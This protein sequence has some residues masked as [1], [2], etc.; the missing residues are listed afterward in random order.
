MKNNTWSTGIIRWQIWYRW[1]HER[2]GR[3]EKP[4]RPGCTNF[5]SFFGTYSLGLLDL[6]GPYGLVLVCA[7][8]GPRMSVSHIWI[9]STFP[10]TQVNVLSHTEFALY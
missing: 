9:S 4:V 5:F 10:L 1:R 2:W 8:V 3:T 6:H 7:Y